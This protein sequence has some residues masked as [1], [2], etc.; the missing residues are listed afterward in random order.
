MKS[1]QFPKL[2]AN[3]ADKVLETSKRL[4]FKKPQSVNNAFIDRAKRVKS[5]AFK[6]PVIEAD[7]GQ[8]T[9]LLL[10]SKVRPHIEYVD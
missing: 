3:L 10:R 6:N 7:Y 8:G 4:P 1:K 9:D 2:P 5:K